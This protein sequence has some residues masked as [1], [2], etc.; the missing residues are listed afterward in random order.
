MAQAAHAA[1]ARSTAHIAHMSTFYD[2]DCKLHATH[3]QVIWQAWPTS[4]ARVRRQWDAPLTNASVSHG[5][6]VVTGCTCSGPARAG[7]ACR[8]CD[9]G[10]AEMRFR[11]LELGTGT[12]RGVYVLGH[13]Q[14]VATVCC[15]ARRAE[16]NTQ[17]PHLRLP[18]KA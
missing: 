17:R 2:K 16:F 12:F 15:N 14:P 5:S 18:H 3:R 13:T 10:M 11:Y 6:A 8:R 1:V 4:L 7:D 9:D